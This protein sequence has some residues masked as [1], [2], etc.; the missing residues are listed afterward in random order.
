MI[1]YMSG[2]SNVGVGGF[3][4]Q[5]ICKLKKKEIK[6][7]IKSLPKIKDGF[8]LV[9]KGKPELVNYLCKRCLG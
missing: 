3:T 8:K 2:N 1:V 7:I 6:D 4:R 5:N 9:G